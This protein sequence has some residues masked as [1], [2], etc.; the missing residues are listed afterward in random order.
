MTGNPQI[1]GSRLE[2]YGFDYLALV[3]ENGAD[4]QTFSVSQL[5]RLSDPGLGHRIATGKLLDQ[6]GDAIATGDIHYAS[7]R[8]A[9]PYL[10]VGQLLPGSSNRSPAPKQF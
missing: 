10:L 1:E 7:T 4:T 2:I 9:Y 6:S 8:S 5:C 3:S